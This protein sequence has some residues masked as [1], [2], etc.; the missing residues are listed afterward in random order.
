MRDE[1]RSLVRNSD[2]AEETVDIRD[3]ALQSLVQSIF[4]ATGLPASA[5]CTVAASLVDAELVGL[6]SHGV[7]L[8][9][10][11][12]ERIRTGSVSLNT[13][14]RV[15]HD[16]GAVAV[17]D[18]GNALGQL[19]AKQAMNMA[20]VHAQ[21]Y[22]LGAAAVRHAFHFG[23]AG[24]YALSAAERGCIGV[25]MCNTRPLM[26]C[27][28][29]AEPVVGNNPIAISVPVAGEIPLVLDMALSEAAMGRIRMAHADGRDIPLGWATDTAGL[30]TTDP[31]AAI[32]GMLLPAGGA[33]GFG[34]AFMI[35]VLCGVLSSGAWGSQ[36][37][38]LYG[39]RSIPYDCSHFFLAIDVRR[40]RPLEEFREEVVVAAARVRTS[41]MAPGVSRLYTPGEI[42]WRRR[43]D[44]RE[45]GGIV[46]LPPAT[47]ASLK[48]A[49]DS[50]N[51]DIT[52]FFSP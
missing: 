16:N 43:R 5:A 33:K 29:G 25:A 32:A 26:P 50:L 52:E 49:A 34:L 48:A 1:S 18:A 51:V 44:N 30:P 42:E 45:H 38:P 13:E 10:M 23:A 17:L 15:I 9:P 27:P 12:V 22:G 40:F 19:T 7:M 47:V 37:K 21:K 35:D 8:V 39:D 14:A 6:P 41:K 3:E 36:V 28:G 11:Y 31:A 24:P 2:Q 46:I 4:R 20:V